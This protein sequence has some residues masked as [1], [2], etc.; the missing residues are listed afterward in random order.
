LIQSREEKMEEPGLVGKIILKRV[1]TGIENAVVASI[2]L[3][4]DRNHLFTA[5]IW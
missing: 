2:P 5:S 4:Q 3:A 1:L